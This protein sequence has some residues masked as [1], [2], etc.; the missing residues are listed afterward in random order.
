M[1]QFTLSSGGNCNYYKRLNTL[2]QA[3]RSRSPRARAGLFHSHF[4][5][6]NGDWLRSAAEVPVPLESPTLPRS[7]GQRRC[8]SPLN[9]PLCLDQ[10]DWHL[11]VTLGA[12]SLD[13]GKV[14]MKQ[15]C[16][17]WRIA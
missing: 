4:G 3:G 17:G 16:S 14:R 6:F 8:L 7:R 13:R 5:W 9:R 2:R 10:G 1:Y 11:A 12:S 15:P